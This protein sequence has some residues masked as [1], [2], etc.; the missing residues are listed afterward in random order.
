MNTTKTLAADMIILMFVAAPAGARKSVETQGAQ[1]KSPVGSAG[2]R[3]GGLAQPVGAEPE[4]VIGPEDV[5][6]TNIWEEP[7]FSRTVQHKHLGSLLPA[8]AGWQ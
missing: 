8:A 3:W 2:R 6:E 4:W 5:V 1:K 7:R